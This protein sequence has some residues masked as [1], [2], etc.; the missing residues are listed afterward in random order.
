MSWTDLLRFF[1]GAAWILALG[2]IP[3]IASIVRK[4]PPI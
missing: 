1:C 2:V 4:N 3:A